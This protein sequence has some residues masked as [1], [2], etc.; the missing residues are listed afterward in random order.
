[1]IVL[2]GYEEDKGGVNTKVICYDYDFIEG[3]LISIARRWFVWINTRVLL[4]SIVIGTEQIN[5]N[6]NK[7]G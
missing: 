3:I 2:K 1:M 4:Y 7:H 5:Y 6:R